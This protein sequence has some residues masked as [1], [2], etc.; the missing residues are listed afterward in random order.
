MKAVCWSPQTSGM[1]ALLSNPAGS[2]MHFSDSYVV[3]PPPHPTFL[4]CSSF[5]ATVGQQLSA[6]KSTGM[7]CLLPHLSPLSAIQSL[8]AGTES[9]VK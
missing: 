2:G 5:P 4:I 3:L 7:A 6:A 9:C 8:P 1:T